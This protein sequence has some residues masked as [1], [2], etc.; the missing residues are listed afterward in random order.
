MNDKNLYEPGSLAK[1]RQKSIKK[2]KKS[3]LN[4]TLKSIAIGKIKHIEK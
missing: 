1:L 4:E 3:K 2:I